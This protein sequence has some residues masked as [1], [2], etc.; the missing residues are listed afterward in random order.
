MLALLDS[1][2]PTFVHCKEGKDRTGTV[3][4]CY[5][6][7]HDRWQNKTALKEAES[8]GMHW[9]EFGMKRY[10]QNYQTSG[11]RAAAESVRAV[12]N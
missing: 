7:L 5:R 11:E 4:A 12:A 10:I 3:I 8:Y 1:G 6:M 9:F 2:E